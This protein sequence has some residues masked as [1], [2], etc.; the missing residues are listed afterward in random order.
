MLTVR[1]DNYEVKTT[2]VSLAQMVFDGKLDRHNPARSSDG[3]IQRSLERVLEAPYLEALTHELLTRLQSMYHR[4]EP[5][6][7]IESLRARVE[8]LCRWHWSRSNTRARFLWGAAWLNE[9]TDRFETAVGYYDAF[10]QTRCREPHL[11][12]LAYNNRGVLRIRIGRRDGVQDLA[13]SAI[14]SK[15][16]RTPSVPMS[17]LPAACFNLLNLIDVALEIDSLC[18]AVDE[19]LTEFFKQLPEKTRRVWLGTES[20]PQATVTMCPSPSMAS[21]ASNG[22]TDS[23][24]GSILG[25]PTHKSLNRLTSNLASRA[26]LLDDP[27]TTDQADDPKRPCQLMLWGDRRASEREPNNDFY[28]EPGHYADAATLLLSHQVPSSLTSRTSPSQRAEQLAMEELAEI[29]SLVAAG[30]FD[31]A[32]SRLEVQRKILAGMDHQDRAGSLLAR[33]DAELLWIQ[34]AEKELEQLQLQRACTKLVSEVEQFCKLTS[35]ARAERQVEELRHRLNEQRVHLAPQATKELGDL[36]EE[37]SFR[38]ERHMARLR[39]LDVRKRIRASLRQLRASW[40]ADWTT[41]V[42]DRA[43]KALAQCQLIDPDNRVQDWPRLREQLDAHQAQHR[44]RTAV[45]EVSSEILSSERMEAALAEALSLHPDAWRTIAPRF[46]L[47]GESS[48]D[49]DATTRA[50]LRTALEV[51]AGRLLHEPPSDAAGDEPDHRR[52]LLRHA[53]SL[54]DQAFR[55]LHGD[56]IRF[57][58]L[59][60]CVRSTLEPALADATLEGIADVEEIAGKCLGHWPARKVKMLTQSDPRNPVRLFLEVCEKTRCLTTAERLLDT[61]PTKG[62]EARECVKRAVGI[63]LDSRDQVRRAATCIYL[64]GLCDDD[65]PRTQRHLLDSI[66][67]WV[68]ELTDEVVPQID[69]EQ[70]VGQIETARKRLLKPTDKLTKERIDLSD[71]DIETSNGLPTGTDC[72]DA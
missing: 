68:V 58:R 51:A 40:P 29:E 5:S 42:S 16:D 52:D 43:Y 30:N 1:V 37:L 31:L 14:P 48:C 12:L 55:R 63:G 56:P 23:P 72:P 71:E 53:G 49:S 28:R 38:A 59:W 33:V 18:Q 54:L 24:E 39:R 27:Q 26:R 20:I 65:S 13:K 60:D 35:L 34:N 17:G 11:R 10:L 15:P 7:S 57:L 62:G 50:D 44:L 19:E 46:G 25:D 22:D 3:T 9:L 8:S 45:A 2:P 61:D 4:G 32:R 69:E 41:P 36:L 47:T 70:I 6:E 66:D 67:A 21:H 64:A